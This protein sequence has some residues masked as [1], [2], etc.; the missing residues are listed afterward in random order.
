MNHALEVFLGNLP[1]DHVE[2]WLPAG[3]ARTVIL[4]RTKSGR[5]RKL[6][7]TEETLEAMKAEFPT[8]P[9]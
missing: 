8:L 3:S 6:E 4:L 1:N 9:W 5:V 2:E 7:M